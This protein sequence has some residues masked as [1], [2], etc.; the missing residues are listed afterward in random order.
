MLVLMLLAGPAMADPRME[1]A[2]Q[3]IPLEPF[4]GAFVV[5]ALLNGV[6]TEKFIVDSGSADVSLPAE[7]A[8][9]LKEL[10]ALKASDLLGSKTYMLA[11]GSKVSSDIYRISSIAIGGTVVHD[12]TVR[13][14]PE[15]S[16]LLLGQS[17]LSRLNSWSI[18]N[19]HKVMAIN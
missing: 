7:I 12:V 13:I 2:P 8:S 17:F 11:D 6:L 14:S 9:R 10:G 3:P 5:P 1:P 4:N 15:R 18:D 19:A 16:H